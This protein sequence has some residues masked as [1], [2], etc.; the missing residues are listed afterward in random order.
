VNAPR[1]TPV[2]NAGYYLVTALLALTVAVGCL[3]IANEL[4]GAARGGEMPV[5]SLSVDAALAPGQLRSLPNGI[6]VHEDVRLSAEVVDPTSAQLLLAAG[7]Q[8]GPL[9]L[10]VASLSLL[11]ALARSVR[12]RE[13]F[14]EANVRRLRA[15]GFLLV[16]GSPVVAAVNWALRLALGNTSPLSDL[17]T[18]GLSIE[19]A[20]LIAGLGAFVLAEVFAHGVRLREDVEATI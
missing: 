15:L 8:V 5:G 17:S 18:A 19:A 10:L 13:P 20:P 1:P 3:V 2:S 16:V 11:R 9:A 14:G 6:K 4:V 7:T 12:E